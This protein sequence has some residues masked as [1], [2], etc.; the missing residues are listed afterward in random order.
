M[1]KA[2]RL[3]IQLEEPFSCS[4]EPALSNEI[5]TTEFIPATTVRGA[6][7]AALSRRNTPSD[8]MEAWFGLGGLCFSNALPIEED[9][10]Y[11]PMPKSFLVDKGDS[12]DFDGA[13]GVHNALFTPRDQLSKSTGSHRHQWTRAGAN[14]VAVDNAGCLVRSASLDVST[15]M[16]IALDYPTQ[17][18]L[19]SALFSRQRLPSGTRYEAWVFDSAGTIMEQ[20][21]RVF[22]GNDEVREMA[23]RSCSGVK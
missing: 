17:S 9:L 3:E 10:R 8:V 1:T 22:L 5:D 16:H 19:G 4:S 2:W 11:V 21:A 6:L 7:A 23:L 12:S 14:W 20:P 18:V 13:F 15:S